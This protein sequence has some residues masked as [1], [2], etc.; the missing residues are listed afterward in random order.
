MADLPE[1]IQTYKYPL[2]STLLYDTPL[3][4][5]PSKADILHQVLQAYAVGQKP[6]IDA[7]S[8]QSFSER[9]PYQV[10]TGGVG[11][12]R[13]HGSLTHRAGF[14]GAM[15]GL[16]GYNFLASQL[17][18]A[19]SD[20]DVKAIMLDVDSP[21]GS[22]SGLFELC[23]EIKRVSAEKP[24][25]ALSNESMFSAAYAIGAAAGKVL[26]QR[27]AMAGSIGV[28]MMHLDQSKANEKS[29]RKYTPIYAGHHKVDGSSHAPLSDQARQTYQH[30]VDD[31]YQVFTSHVADGRG[32]DQQ[33]VIDTQAQIYTAP[34]AIDVGLIDQIASY[35]E[36][37]DM[38][39]AEIRPSVS[40]TL[41]S[42]SNQTEKS[43]SKEEKPGVQ[44][45]AI[46]QADLDAARTEGREEGLEAGRGEERARVTSILGL[47]SAAGKIDGTLSAAL[48]KGL[49][50][51]TAG[52]FLKA[53]PE[54][55]GNAF[56]A[57][58]AATA[59]PDVSADGGADAELTDDQMAARAVSLI[60]P[61]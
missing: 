12:I 18:A 52:E 51:E 50:A 60:Q 16:T 35:D 7:A 45:S 15:S 34:D 24:V 59:N 26:A 8:F 36:A 49:D 28:I 30:L 5:A 61:K 53:V 33:A 1:D 17:R 27:T 4:M 25:W 38:L 42:A 40:L 39:E 14:L 3:M 46:T 6:A 43:M 55:K 37:L 32:L 19:E 31:A 57:A 54:Q 48:C 20:R 58:M 56:E 44:A 41:A 9:K 11:V 23:A 13:V 2:L 21:G 29:G 47:E 10:T 22:V